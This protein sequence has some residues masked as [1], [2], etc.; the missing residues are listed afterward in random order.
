MI[1]GRGGVLLLGEELGE[2]GLAVGG[3]GENEGEMEGDSVGNLALVAVRGGPGGD[4][5]GESG[6]C[7]EIG[8]SG[9]AVG[10]R[11]R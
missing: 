7:G 3:A 6:G 10:L 8:V 9:D 2:G 5:A 4:V 1:T 11:S